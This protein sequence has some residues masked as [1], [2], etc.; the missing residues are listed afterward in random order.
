MYYRFNFSD[1]D[2]TGR[3]SGEY[4]TLSMLKKYVPLT[5]FEDYDNNWGDGT[6]FVYRGDCQKSC[7]PLNCKSLQEA[8]ENLLEA[9]NL[10]LYEYWNDL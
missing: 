1:L 8:Y 3:K 5:P 10:S 7:E 9:K 4:Y 2:K 6:W